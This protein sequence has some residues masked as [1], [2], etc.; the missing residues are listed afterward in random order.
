MPATARDDS[1][2]IR[3]VILHDV[4][5]WVESEGMLRVMARLMQVPFLRKRPRTRGLLY[6]KE[7]LL[8]AAALGILILIIVAAF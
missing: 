4:R 6:I 5:R 2:R 8:A 1:R 3:P 7:T